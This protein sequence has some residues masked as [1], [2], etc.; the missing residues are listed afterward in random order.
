ME[1]RG[2][3]LLHWTRGC[4]TYT[5]NDKVPAR[6]PLMTEAEIRDAFQKSFDAWRAIDCGDGPSPFYVEQAGGFIRDAESEFVFDRSNDSIVSARTREEWAAAEHDANALALTL[7]WHD[8]DTGEILDV[9]MELNT[10]AGR[11]TDCE[12]RSCGRDTMDLRNTVTHEAGHLLGLGHS[13][14]PKCQGCTM[15]L[16]APDGETAKRS[17]ENDDIDGYCSLGLPQFECEDS[18]C[19]CPA[20]PVYPS[21]RTVKTCACT[22]VGADAAAP[23]L[24]WLAALAGVVGARLRRARKR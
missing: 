13:A 5:F 20:A 8:A 17:L 3:P 10:G 15:L 24:A 2:V 6:L 19:S 9:D 4:M 12:K 14:E 7:L 1:E 18:S 16:D 23:P 22:A 11:F 21:K